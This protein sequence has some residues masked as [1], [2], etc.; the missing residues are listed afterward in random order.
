MILMYHKVDLESLTGWWVDIDNFYRQLCEL[1]CKKVVY[2]DDYDPIDQDQVV[3]AFDG[4]Y[5]NILQYAAPL[6][7]KF[8]YPFE[9]FVIGD[10]IGKNNSFDTVEPLTDFASTED[11]K[12]L[13]EL[14]GRIQWHTRTHLNLKDIK[15]PKE[16]IKEIK[17]SV[18]LKNLDKHG[19]KWFA[20]PNGDINQQVIDI[21]K[22]YFKG[23]VSCIQGN[24]L[25][26]Y[27]LNRAMVKSGSSFKKASIAV[28]IPSYN[29]GQFLV[30]AV[31]S[32]I[33]QTRQPDEILISDDCSNDNTEEIA[34]FY[35]NKYPNLIRYNRND[36]NLG[37]IKHFNKA[38]SLTK[39]DYV[40][41][42]GADNRFR[43]DYI[44]KTA[45]VLD[46]DDKIAIAYTDCALFGSRAKLLYDT[47]PPSQKRGVVDGIYYIVV[48]PNFSPNVA[49]EMKNK[50]VMHGSSMYKRKAFTE[51]EGYK[52]GAF[53]D[54]NLFYRMI[55]KGWLAKR[56]PFPVL[57]YRQ[58]SVEQM[59]IRI[60]SLQELIFY[61]SQYQ[62]L[63]A[64]QEE[65]KKIKNSKF[66]KLLF[67]YKN[68]K[69]GFKRYTIKI[70]KKIFQKIRHVL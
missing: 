60:Q 56:V 9:L 63:V 29:Y 70:P 34:R 35:K 32:V 42:L 3:I 21:T 37:I 19:M 58:H 54:H 18:K 44:E 66:W 55:E 1:K 59:N 22:K 62:Q 57:Q 27:K 8:S 65:L 15:D 26:R 49:S 2:L 14:G 51:V 53:E 6:L 30:E 48:F 12:K 4:V 40:C 24:E 45:E 68:P 43:S 69:E 31:E 38:V 50:N 16:I 7:K 23:A 52:D 39:S 67:V 41:F 5:K 28:I 36:K 46:S 13:I 20:Y 25:D 47:V 11:L 33:R 64:D 17:P 61:K 10:C